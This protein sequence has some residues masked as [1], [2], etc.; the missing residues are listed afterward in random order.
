MELAIAAKKAKEQIQIQLIFLFI[1]YLNF[2]FL[3]KTGDSKLP[4]RKATN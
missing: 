1:Y 2:H 4:T 3:L